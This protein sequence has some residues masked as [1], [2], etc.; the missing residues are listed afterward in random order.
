MARQERIIMKIGTD[1][2]LKSLDKLEE[3]LWKL[4]D[5]NRNCPDDQ[6]T[7]V[8]QIMEVVDRRCSLKRLWC[9]HHDGKEPW[10]QTEDDD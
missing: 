8:H 9:Q 3:R 7:F 5:D 10:Q 2:E 4:I 1:N 6:A